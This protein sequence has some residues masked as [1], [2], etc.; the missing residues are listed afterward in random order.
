MNYIFPTHIAIDQDLNDHV[1]YVRSLN[2]DDNKKR[3]MVI[4][5]VWLLDAAKFRTRSSF[6]QKKVAV[7]FS[8]SAIIIY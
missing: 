5:Q 3:A 6:R 4:Q 7:N 2:D 8:L 1:N